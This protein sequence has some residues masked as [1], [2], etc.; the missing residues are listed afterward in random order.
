VR[1]DRDAITVHNQIRALDPFPGTTSFLGDKLLKIGR[2]EPAGLHAPHAAS[3]TVL[4]VSERG[5]EVACGEGIVRLLELQAPGR[6]MMPVAE[7]LRGFSVQP[8][9]VFS[10]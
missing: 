2:A 10:S 7:F 4:A 3:G 5:L 6:R 8:G 9:Q 1:W